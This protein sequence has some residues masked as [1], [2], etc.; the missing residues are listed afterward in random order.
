[1]LSD[2]RTEKIIS[3]VFGNLNAM[4]SSNGQKNR[5]TITQTLEKSVIDAD[6]QMSVPAELRPSA[7][8]SNG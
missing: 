3:C 7:C 1:M 4:S 6:E 2:Q 5:P 8:F